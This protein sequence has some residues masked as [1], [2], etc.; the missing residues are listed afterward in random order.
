MKPDLTWLAGLRLTEVV[1]K[2]YTWFFVFDDGSTIS[3]ESAWRL[4]SSAEIIVTSEDDGHHFGFAA[5]VNAAE[6]V[7]LTVAQSAI[8]WHG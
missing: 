8:H 2:D 4:L 6:R 5:P 7:T 3:T 1:Q